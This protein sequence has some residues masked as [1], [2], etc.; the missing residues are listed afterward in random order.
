MKFK[1][2]EGFI[3]YETYGEIENPVIMF[4][5]AL[6]ADH[7]M[8]DGQ[9]DRFKYDYYLILVDLPWHGMSYIPD[10]HLDFDEVC[11]S[12][13]ALLENLG[14]DKMIISGTSL[15][16]YIAQYFAFIYPSKIIAL[17]LDGS[18]PMHYK[19]NFLSVF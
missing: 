14:I 9:V 2:E 6:G 5:H 4:L 1:T 12:L 13:F 18:H 19:F 8:F 16:G 3:Y 7:H 15:G 10:R 17:H 11:K